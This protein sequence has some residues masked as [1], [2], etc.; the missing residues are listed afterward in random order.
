MGPLNA[1]FR[2]FQKLGAGDLAHLN[3]SLVDHLTGAYNLLRQWEAEEVLCKAW[4]FHA[5]YGTA[6]FQPSLVGVKQ[7]DRIA[8][9][10]GK[11]A[12]E[13]IYTYCACDRATDW[14]GR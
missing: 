7:R 2:E 12:E 4:L 13:I 9:I 1:E 14:K 11:P 10:V 5:T 6:S 3:G 8:A